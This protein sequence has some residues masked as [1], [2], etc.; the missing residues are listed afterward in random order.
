MTSQ[1]PTGNVRYDNSDRVVVVTG[2]S[3]GIG[4]AICE[5]FAAS[6]ADVVCLDTQLPA[7]SI[8]AEFV[9]CDVTSDSD[10]E[11]AVNHVFDR[12]GAIDVLINNAAIQP[13]E[14]YRPVDEL[15]ADI[16]QPMIDTNL[17]GYLRMAK[18]VLPIMRKQ[19]SGVIINMASGQA[20]RTAR[21]VGIYGPIKSANVMQARQWAV[22]YARCGIR[23]VSISP[24]AID[25]P[26]V[27]ATLEQQGGVES[28]A[29]RHPIGRIG[30]P[31]EVASAALW[32]CSEEA[33]FVTGTDLEVDGGLG[34]FGAFADPFESGSE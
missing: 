2:G 24:G 28:L 32:L 4:H 17:T 13:K 29:N 26:M 5:G 33:S 7:D 6:G 19:R 31:E 22:E 18:Q 10:C 1:R 11:A 30:R 23:V 21:Q 15:S 34:A 9:R 25:T 8:D 20:H 14:S 3:S 27:R 16:W 12:F